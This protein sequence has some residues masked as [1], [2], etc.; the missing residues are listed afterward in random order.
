MPSWDDDDTLRPVVKVK[1][2]LKTEVANLSAAVNKAAPPEPAPIA[3]RPESELV[4][5]YLGPSEKTRTVWVNDD[6]NEAINVDHV[7]GQAVASAQ[8]TLKSIRAYTT[9]KEAQIGI[10]LRAGKGVAG[11]YPGSV[12]RVDFII[13]GDLTDYGKEFL[14]GRSMHFFPKAP[15]PSLLTEYD[16]IDY[17]LKPFVQE[18][19]RDHRVTV[20]ADDALKLELPGVNLP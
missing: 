4:I 9:D 17:W 14:R 7:I 6:G 8:G 15:S 20:T 2:D 3:P 1:P 11:W 16:F 10:H 13:N 19:L 18:L 12:P 5:T